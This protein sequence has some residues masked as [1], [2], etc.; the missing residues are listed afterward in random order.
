MFLIKIIQK[1]HF[2]VLSA[3]LF[4]EKA[5]KTT[6]KD[7]IGRLEIWPFYLS[8]LNEQDYKKIIK[9][10]VI[11][12]MCNKAKFSSHCHQLLLNRDLSIWRKHKL[13]KTPF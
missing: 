5:N 12:D 11:Y 8:N 7:H 13:S 4:M 10:G 2:S 6:K 1:L 3:V 9:F